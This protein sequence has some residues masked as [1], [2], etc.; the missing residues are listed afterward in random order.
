MMQDLTGRVGMPLAFPLHASFDRSKP[1]G[2]LVAVLDWPKIVATLQAVRVLP[3]GQDERGYLVLANSEGILLAA[4]SFLT[5]WEPG[6]TR[7]N[8]LG[9]ETAGAIM[10]APAGSAGIDVRNSTYLAG[11]ATTEKRPYLPDAWR[12]M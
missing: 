2:V 6:R 8:A 11:Y 10:T 3:E 5:G 1:V 12:T 4:P 9:L 7:L